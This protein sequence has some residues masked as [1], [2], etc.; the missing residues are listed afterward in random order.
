MDAPRPSQL[1]TV[2]EVRAMLEDLD[3]LDQGDSDIEIQITLAGVSTLQWTIKQVKY[4]VWATDKDRSLIWLCDFDDVS[5]FSCEF[6][7]LFGTHNAF[8]MLWNKW[9][10]YLVDK[11]FYL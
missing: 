7:F 3:V 1:F 8:F 5:C 10:H 2:D 6:V 4:F 9:Y 11:S